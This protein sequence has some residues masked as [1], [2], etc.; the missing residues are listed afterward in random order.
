MLFTHA[1]RSKHANNKPYR[2]QTLPASRPVQSDFIICAARTQSG[3]VL[4]VCS[5]RTSC[6]PNMLTINL[7]VAQ[8]KIEE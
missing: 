4:Y 8:K 1:L 5:L 7:V 3:R 6:V 2:Q